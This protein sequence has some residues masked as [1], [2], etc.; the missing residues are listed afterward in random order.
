MTGSSHDEKV[1]MTE[2]DSRYT[3][4]PGACWFSWDTVMES[5]KMRS[6]VS[7]AGKPPAATEANLSTN[8]PVRSPIDRVAK[9]PT[10]SFKVQLHPIFFTPHLSAPQDGPTWIVDLKNTYFPGRP[11]LDRGSEK[12]QGQREEGR[13]QGGL[14]HP[15]LR[16]RFRVD[17]RR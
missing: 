6:V 1:D 16:R 7:T 17:G 8:S 5:G 15:D 11:H 2:K 12:R 13:G 4:N 14:H 3:L 10:T 9:F